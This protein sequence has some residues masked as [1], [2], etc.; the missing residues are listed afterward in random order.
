MAV[1]L[2]SFKA[3]KIVQRIMRVSIYDCYSVARF[4][5]KHFKGEHLPF[6][7][8]TDREGNKLSLEELSPEEYIERLKEGYKTRWR[9][10]KE[11]LKSLGQHR[12]I[13]LV[14]WCPY[15]R[16]SYK[17]L[18]EERHFCCHT[19]LIGQMINRHRP[20]ITVVLDPDRSRF[21]HEAWKPRNYTTLERAVIVSEQPARQPKKKHEQLV[22][23]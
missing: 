23:F 3:L 13:A 15:S 14:C 20:D 17:Q 9:E 5:P 19:G 8:A 1:V 2:T 6:L 11:W 21:L 10:I 7:G 18:K 4:S 16:H 22:M 12:N